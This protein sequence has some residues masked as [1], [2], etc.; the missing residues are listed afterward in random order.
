MNMNNKCNKEL[1]ALLKQ[2]KQF[3]NFIKLKKSNKTYTE[4]LSTIN[5]N[6]RLKETFFEYFKMYLDKKNLL[7]TFIYEHEKQHGK[8]FWMSTIDELI[9]Y[10]L[11]WQA[12]F[13]GHLFWALEDK[14]WKTHIYEILMNN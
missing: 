12:T 1:I 14:R 4:I 6:A 8:R 11:H 2:R 13:Q 7:N 9:N 10:N 3:I 5:K